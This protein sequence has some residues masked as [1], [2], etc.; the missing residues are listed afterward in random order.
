MRFGEL[1]IPNLEGKNTV[2]KANLLEFSQAMQEL[3]MS[4]RKNHEKKRT[5]L[6]ISKKYEFPLDLN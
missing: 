5:E 6:T 1:C 4:K 3:C 2:S